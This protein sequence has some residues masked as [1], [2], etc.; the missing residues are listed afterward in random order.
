MSL[1]C[2]ACFEDKIA[3][4]FIRDNGFQGICGFC[5]ARHHK[6]VSAHKLRPLFEEVVGLY[7]PYEPA[8]GSESWK[9]E[10]L[11][12]CMAG[13]DIFNADRD[14][15]VQNSILDEI[16]GFDPH[17]GDLSASDDWQAKSD[18]WAA[19]PLHERWRWFA[20]HLKGSRRFIIE[21]DA[22]GEIVRPETWLPDAIR[23]AD[24]GIGE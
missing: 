15:K 9:G 1:V 13:W 12:E 17:D 10:T 11:S 24:A 14:N 8:P 2:A 6:V 22:T 21:E 5:G 23:E 18:H 4:R 3:R 20:E 19:T 16:I 7:R